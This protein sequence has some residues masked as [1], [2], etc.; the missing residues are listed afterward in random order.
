MQAPVFLVYP[1]GDRAKRVE[2]T[3]PKARQELHSVI[4]SDD[5]EL[6]SESFKMAV[7]EGLKQII[8]DTQT[9]RCDEAKLATTKSDPKHV[10]DPIVTGF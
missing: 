1:T 4:Q 6:F 10:I 9:V 3:A 5:D 7:F 2:A 8:E